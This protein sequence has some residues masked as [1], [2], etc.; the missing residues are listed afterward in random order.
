MGRGHDVGR[1]TTRGHT[2][3]LYKMNRSESL[4]EARNWASDCMGM[5]GSC[6][7]VERA[8]RYVERYY[9]GGWDGFIQD[10]CTYVMP[11]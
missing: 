11:S 1:T 4:Q 3:K 2:V 5:V 8:L 7:G 9:P 6:V 10:C